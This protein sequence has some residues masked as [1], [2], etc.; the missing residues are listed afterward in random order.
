MLIKVKTCGIYSIDVEYTQ[1]LYNYVIV[2]NTSYLMVTC[3][4]FDNI[5][6]L[7]F[8]FTW[9]HVSLYPDFNNKNYVRLVNFLCV[10]YCLKLI[11]IL[12]NKQGKMVNH[13]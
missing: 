12:Y 2:S 4:E 3:I 13:V 6:V 11:T 10:Y 1:M 9:N 5:I 7:R 8:P